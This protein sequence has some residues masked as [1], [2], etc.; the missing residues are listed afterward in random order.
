MLPTFYA[1]N[2]GLLVTCSGVHFG[3]VSRDALVRHLMQHR[4]L[5]PLSTWSAHP[6][7]IRSFAML[8]E[9]VRQK[10]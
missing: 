4:A 7:S 1:S 2:S 3:L 8:G 10:L 5:S 6:L 9:K